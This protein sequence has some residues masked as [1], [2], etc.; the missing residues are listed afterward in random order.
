MMSEFELNVARLVDPKGDLSLDEIFT[1]IESKF[2]I[3]NKQSASAVC[4][5]CHGYDIDPV[6]DGSPLECKDCGHKWK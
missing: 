4:P 6:Y 2:T 5:K 3:D 1:L